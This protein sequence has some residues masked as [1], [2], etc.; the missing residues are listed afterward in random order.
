MAASLSSQLEEE[1]CQRLSQ[2]PF[3]ESFVAVRSSGT[4][5]DSATH[6]F[7]GQFGML[8][9][10]I[11]VASYMYECMC[12]Q[13]NTDVHVHACNILLLSS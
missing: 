12:L 4:D 6:S 10:W 2:E 8:I 9:S 7:A 5:E 3:S 11:I 1:L 13:H